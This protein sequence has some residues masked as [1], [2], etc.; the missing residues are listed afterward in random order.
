MF[1]ISCGIVGEC[2]QKVSDARCVD[3]HAL[4]CVSIGADVVARPTQQSL[5][6]QLCWLVVL[7]AWMCVCTVGSAALARPSQ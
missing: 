1:D 3:V 6:E 7:N 4:H 5:K 2:D